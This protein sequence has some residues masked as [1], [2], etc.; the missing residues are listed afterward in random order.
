M[1]LAIK[2]DGLIRDGVIANHAELARLG[3]VTRARVAQIM[4]LL[5]LAPDIQEAVLFQ[6]R[7]ER[8]RHPIVLR[9]VL[10]IAASLDWKK[11][12]KLWAELVSSRMSTSDLDTTRCYPPI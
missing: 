2:C 12:R 4:G 5:A 3:H 11:Q 8:G 7:T 1:A 9:D 6:L 10:P